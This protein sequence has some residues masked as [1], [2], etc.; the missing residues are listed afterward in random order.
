MSQL[1]LPAE[2]TEAD[3]VLA[4]TIAERLGSDELYVVWTDDHGPAV[5]EVA[6]LLREPAPHWTDTLAFV[7]Q[8]VREI[9][10]VLLG[11]DTLAP[12]A[13]RPQPADAPAPQVKPAQGEAAA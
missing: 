10:T 5:P 4:G 11:R 2:H 1:Y 8:A 12:Q 6:A 9:W 3:L 7:F 13:G